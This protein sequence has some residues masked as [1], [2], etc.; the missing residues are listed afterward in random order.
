MLGSL[1]EAEPG[2]D[3]VVLSGKPKETR[4]LYGTKAVGRFNPLGVFI[5]LFN[6][7]M[8][9]F[10]GGSLLQDVTSS[11]SLFYYL[12]VI[13]LALLLGKKVMLYANGIG[14][15]QNAKNR[16]RVRAV[17]DRANVITLREEFSREE[18][19]ALG[20]TRPEIFVTA[21]PAVTLAPAAEEETRALFALNGAALPE[22]YAVI[23]VRPY[24]GARSDFDDVCAAGCDHLARKGITPVFIPMQMSR[25]LAVSERIL[26]R[27][28]E[29]GMCVNFKLSPEA[30]LG[31]ISRAEAVV[32][33]R[34]HAL[35]FAAASGRAA[36]G[37][38]YDI[39]VRAFMQ[40]MG[41]KQAVEILDLTEERFIKEIDAVLAS[42]ERESA[43]L[44]EKAGE[45]KTLARKNARRAAELYR[46]KTP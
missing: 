11:K 27:M 2:L 14:P 15:V 21:D 7:E 39:K 18:I 19:R 3:I 41:Q 31:V 28:R 24:R 9:L 43:R 42:A 8:L 5:A 33:E 46:L 16:V 10:G 34:L 36:V 40:S 4:R 25:D 35:I 45:L 13:R 37:I 38:V 17:L 44:A 6:C 1:K 29:R 23:A 22:K 26:S 12:C 20:I 30:A 32:G